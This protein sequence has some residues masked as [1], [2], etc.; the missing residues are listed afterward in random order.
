[1]EL[2]AVYGTLMDGQSY[3]GRPDV[4]KLLRSRGPC[5]I[6]GR[7]HDL[8]RGYPGLVAGDKGEVSGELYEVAD[9]RTLGLLDAYEDDEY[10][11]R[12]VRLIAP[13]ET[14]WVY[15]YVGDSPGEAIDDGDWRAFLQ[16]RGER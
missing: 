9:P 14:A 16:I 13:D 11:R 12:R 1:V 15:V 3:E 8:G 6:P 7:L 4:E 2:L 5:R 10:E